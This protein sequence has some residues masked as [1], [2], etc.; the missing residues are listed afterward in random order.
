MIAVSVEVP[1]LFNMSTELTTGGCSY[2]F[3]SLIAT[4]VSYFVVIAPMCAMTTSSKL[5]DKVKF[6]LYSAGFII[7]FASRVWLSIPWWDFVINNQTMCSNI[8]ENYILQYIINSELI[9]ASVVIILVAVVLSVLRCV[10]CHRQRKAK[11]FYKNDGEN[12]A[13]LTGV[14]GIT[15]VVGAANIGTV[16]NDYVEGVL[17]PDT[18]G[19]TPEY[20]V[21]VSGGEKSC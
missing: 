4:V 20:F 5:A 1:I 16:S 11:Y 9:M 15:D 13:V 19:N 6:T 12:Q 17:V 18:G 2:A 21:T 7:Y 14:K 3:Y 8:Q 10:H